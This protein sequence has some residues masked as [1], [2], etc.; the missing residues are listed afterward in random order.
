M[1]PAA[2]RL[3]GRALLGAKSRVAA[4]LL[5]IFLG[6]LGIHNFYLG[7]IGI[8]LIQL[9][10]TVFSAGILGVLVWVWAIIE[11]VLILT[12]SPSFATDK[13]GIPLRD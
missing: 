9:L 1:D 5:A 8:G 4:G 13:R 7:R 6:S 11:G 2:G 3:P 10:V 12:R